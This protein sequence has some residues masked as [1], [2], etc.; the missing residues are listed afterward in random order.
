[1]REDGPACAGWRR[2][3]TESFLYHQAPWLG[4]IVK[5]HVLPFSGAAMAALGNMM[6]HYMHPKVCGRAPLMQLDQQPCT[7]G[8]AVVHP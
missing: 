2:L 4:A 1:M 3:M 6:Y 7:T 5:K 8:G